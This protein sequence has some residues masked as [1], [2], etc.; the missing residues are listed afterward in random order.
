MHLQSKL[1]GSLEYLDAHFRRDR[2]KERDI[3]KSVYQIERN[4]FQDQVKCKRDK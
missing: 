2:E 3:F 1:N 4:T